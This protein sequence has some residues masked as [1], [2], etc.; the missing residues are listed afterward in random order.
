M[1]KD[2]SAVVCSICRLAVLGASALAV[3]TPYRH[4]VRLSILKQEGT[5]LGVEREDGPLFGG[6]GF[7]IVTVDMGVRANVIGMANS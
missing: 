6:L 5:G 2:L 1:A 3:V 4:P 7:T